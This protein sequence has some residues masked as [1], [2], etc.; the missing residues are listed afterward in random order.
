M[1]DNRFSCVLG[2][3]I[4]NLVE[5]NEVCVEVGDKFLLCIDGFINMVYDE[6]I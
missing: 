6:C 2:Y 1:G 3:G 4:I 5:I